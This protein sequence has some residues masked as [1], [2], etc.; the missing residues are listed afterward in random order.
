MPEIVPPVPTAQQMMS[1]FLIFF[2]K[3]F[4]TTFYGQIIGATFGHQIKISELLLKLFRNSSEVFSLYSLR[5][6]KC[7][8]HSAGSGE[9]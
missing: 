2:G 8:L 7:R 1:K 3:D 4:L 9:I 6:T 5:L